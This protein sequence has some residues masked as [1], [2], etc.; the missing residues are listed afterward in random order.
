[1]QEMKLDSSVSFKG[2][3]HIEVR[4]AEG[5]LKETREI[6]NLV[7]Q[8]GLA[9]FISRMKDAAAS[10]LSHMAVGTTNTAAAAAQTT[11]AAEVAR[12]AINS[13]VIST[14]SFA[15]DSL[16]VTAV[17]PAGTGT[18]ALV[19]VGMFNDAASGSMIARAIFDVITKGAADSMSVIWTL[20]GA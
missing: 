2:K 15:N 13:A 18:G 10:A 9:L 3:L 17:F 20:R 14:T 11:L 8:T 5:A 12:V 4:D 16:V 7:V 19:E 6:D 1:M